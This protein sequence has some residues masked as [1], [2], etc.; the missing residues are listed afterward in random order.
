M[1]KMFGIDILETVLPF[2][3]AYDVKNFGII[4]NNYLSGKGFWIELTA[5]FK[6]GIT[7]S[8]SFGATTISFDDS[9]VHVKGGFLNDIQNALAM[10]YNSRIK[11]N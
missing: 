4:D 5:H 11:I 8:F 6:I 3:G 2:N 10:L 9:N 1:D 7:N